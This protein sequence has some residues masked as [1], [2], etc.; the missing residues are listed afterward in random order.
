MVTYLFVGEILQIQSM[1]LFRFSSLFLS[2]SLPL[3]LSSSFPL[4]LSFSLSLF[5]F[6]FLFRY[7][8]YLYSNFS[9]CNE[10]LQKTC[11]SNQSGYIRTTMLH[12]IS[13]S[14]PSPSTPPDLSR[15]HFCLSPPSLLL[16]FF[17]KMQIWIAEAENNKREQTKV[18]HPIQ[19][20]I[21]GLEDHRVHN[22]LG[23]PNDIASLFFF[24]SLSLPLSRS[25]PLSPFPLAFAM[26]FDVFDTSELRNKCRSFILRLWSC[27][28]TYEFNVSLSH[29][30]SPLILS[31]YFTSFYL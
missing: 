17:E 9:R 12:G 20:Q 26:F 14:F 25:C 30:F 16:S 19:R 18:R 22:Q 24:L 11:R 28:I 15:S 1:L 13:P 2:S 29:L 6:L 31:I 8:S 27:S 5:L 10:R 21:S 3:F 7:A 23:H 4:F